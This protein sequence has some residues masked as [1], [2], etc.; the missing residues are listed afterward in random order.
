MYVE[1]RTLLLGLPS[2]AQ[3]FWIASH[4]GH[5]SN[6]YAD[7]L[8]K[9]GAL[10]PGAQTDSLPIPVASLRLVLSRASME[11]WSVKWSSMQKASTT[12][13]FFP[14]IDSAVLISKL[15][16][17]SHVNQ[18]L[19]GHSRLRAFLFKTNCSI[20]PI[21]TCGSDEE[22]VSH[23]LFHCSLHDV[24]RVNFKATS[25]RVLN[26]WP[27]R[28]CDITRFKPLLLSFTSFIAK[29]KHFQKIPPSS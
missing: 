4:H 19:S 16:L 17:P 22:T 12:R 8:A 27:P 10:G 26:M 25:L 28:L 5:Q 20:S 23:F 11:S 1:I 9:Q 13:S 21:C 3:L 14:S 2:T 29:I 24:Y 6:E 18:I 15:D 7:T